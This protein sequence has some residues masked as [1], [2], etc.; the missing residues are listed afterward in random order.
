MPSLNDPAVQRQI[1]LVFL[2]FAAGAATYYLGRPLLHVAAWPSA[3][4]RRLTWR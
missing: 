3:E 2:A 4:I 1:S